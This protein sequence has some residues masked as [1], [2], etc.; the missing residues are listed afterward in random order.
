MDS[1]KGSMITE[2][3]QHL[4]ASTAISV[5]WIV[6]KKPREKEQVSQ[7]NLSPGTAPPK[8]SLPDYERLFAFMVLMDLLSVGLVSMVITQ[9]VSNANYGIFCA[10]NLVTFFGLALLNRIYLLS[11]SQYMLGKFT[12]ITL[13]TLVIETLMLFLFNA[14]IPE[15]VCSLGL[16]TGVYFI[17]SI[18]HHGLTR[19]LLA[20]HHFGL[21][22]EIERRVK[23]GIDWGLSLIFLITGTPLFALIT[24]GIFILD[25]GP[26]I[27]KQTRIG[28]KGQEF[29]LLKFRSMILDAPKGKGNGSDTEKTLFKLENDP[30]VTFLGRLL[31]S[32]SLDELPQLINVFRGEMSLVGPR[33]PLPLEFKE[34][35]EHH[36][37]KFEVLPGMTGLWQVTGRVK[38]QRHFDA[39]A[40]DDI[41]YIEKW[42]VLHDMAILLRTIPVVIG[43]KGAS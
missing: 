33:P 40:N 3:W 31:R 16:I 5:P 17:L 32:F 11:D 7:R 29:T 27:F 25:R 22:Y 42:S 37:R 30:R 13:G 36:R 39:V 6:N 19:H 2:K 26:A 41:N 10:V 24:T 15:I 8:F 9:W 28:L 20:P 34:M 18:F 43:Q 4:A 38:N 14:S 35:N 1:E 23:R 12:L 21:Y